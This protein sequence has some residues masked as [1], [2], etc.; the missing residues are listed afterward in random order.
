MSGMGRIGGGRET[1]GNIVLIHTG[2]CSFKSKLWT[3]TETSWRGTSSRETNLGLNE[4]EIRK[5]KNGTSGRLFKLEI[6]RVGDWVSWRLY[7]SGMER[8]GD[9]R[10]GV[11]RVG[12]G[13]S[14][15]KT[16]E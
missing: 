14:W 3:P 13:T 11:S 5:V 10:V 6:G 8:V 7:E 15:Q 16:I 2:L 4:F 1:S 9:G 12:N